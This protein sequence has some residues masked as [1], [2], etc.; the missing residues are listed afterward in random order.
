MYNNFIKPKA[1]NLQWV[2]VCKVCE[3]PIVTA[4]GRYYWACDCHT[5]QMPLA[6]E[7]ET[8]DVEKAPAVVKILP[9]KN[10]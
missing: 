6:L 5:R 8:K 3:T 10:A 1:L 4:D 7:D 2:W 9:N